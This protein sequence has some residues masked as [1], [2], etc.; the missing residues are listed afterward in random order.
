[1][2]VKR[3][4]VS[5]IVSSFFAVTICH[6]QNGPLSAEVFGRLPEVTNIYRNV[7]VGQSCELYDILSEA[8]KEIKYIEFGGGDHYLRKQMNRI[9]FL[10]EV[11][12]FL[13]KNL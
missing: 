6:A 11:E 1:M 13:A 3:F 7:R 8:G 5:L 12:T 2:F 10:K 4:L 9:Q